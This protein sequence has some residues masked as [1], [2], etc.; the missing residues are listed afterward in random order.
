MDSWAMHLQ[1]G[2]SIAG[3]LRSGLQVRLRLLDQFLRCHGGKVGS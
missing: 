1:D 3:L 2:D